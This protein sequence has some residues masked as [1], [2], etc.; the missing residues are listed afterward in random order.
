MC[1]GSQ[2]PKASEKSPGAKP[3]AFCDRDCRGAIGGLSRFLQASRFEDEGS[4]DDCR[5][6]LGCT[7]ANAKLTLLDRWAVVGLSHRV[8]SFWCLVY[9][10]PSKCN[11]WNIRIFRHTATLALLRLRAWLQRCFTRNCSRKPPPE[12]DTSTPPRPCAILGTSPTR[13]GSVRLAAQ[14]DA[15]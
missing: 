10:P 12:T 15:G 9:Q 8:S 5:S 6:A 14:A 11:G 2:C 1:Q 7:I 4:P 13:S 3:R